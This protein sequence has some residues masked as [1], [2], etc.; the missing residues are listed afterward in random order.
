MSLLEQLC[1]VEERERASR[2][3]DREEMETASGVR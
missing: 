2:G 3:G 1:K